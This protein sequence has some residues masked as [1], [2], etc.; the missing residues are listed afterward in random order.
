[1]RREGVAHG[2]ASNG[3]IRYGGRD[4][5]SIRNGGHSIYTTRNKIKR[6]EDTREVKMGKAKLCLKCGGT[7][8]SCKG[9]PYDMNQFAKGFY[10]KEKKQR[11]VNYLCEDC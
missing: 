1:M 8:Y 7:R 2:I 4:L 5:T 3:T 11:Y 6:F 10:R 9:L